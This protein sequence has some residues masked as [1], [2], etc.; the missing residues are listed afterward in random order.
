MSNNLD[1]LSNDQAAVFAI[2]GELRADMKHIIAGLE[3]AD[4]D[5]QELREEMKTDTKQLNERLNKV[6]KFN[7][8]IAAY[9]AVLIPIL[10]VAVNWIKP[11]VLSL[12]I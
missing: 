12:I 1:N 7:T 11:V 3:R 2:L 5:M 8:K 10:M 6:E 9:A 4:S